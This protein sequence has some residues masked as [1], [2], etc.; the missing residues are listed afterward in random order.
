MFLSQNYNVCEFQIFE[1]NSHVPDLSA[2]KEVFENSLNTF[3][4]M[5]F[6]PGDCKGK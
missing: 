3:E 2:K 6:L 1:R 5:V 4:D